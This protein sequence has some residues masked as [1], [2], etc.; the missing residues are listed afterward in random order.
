LNDFNATRAVGKKP[1]AMPGYKTKFLK[2]KLTRRRQLFKM[3]L[4]MPGKTKFL[5]VNRRDAVS[6]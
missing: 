1:L 3:P 2:I 4:A 5:K 6:F